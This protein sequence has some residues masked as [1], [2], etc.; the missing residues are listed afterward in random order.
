MFL[1]DPQQQVD[2]DLW[3]SYKIYMLRLQ[4][5]MSHIIL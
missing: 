5:N 2:L 3:N 4:F 1:V